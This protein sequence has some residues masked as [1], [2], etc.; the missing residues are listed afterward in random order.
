MIPAHFEFI[1]KLPTSESGKADIKYL[2]SLTITAF[3]RA[4][5]Y[6]APASE[7]ECELVAIWESILKIDKIGMRDNY[8]ELGGDSFKAIKIA[9]EY[10]DGVAV[11][12][13]YNS[14]TIAQLAIA[15]ES[16][17]ETNEGPLVRL[18]SATNKHLDN[19]SIIGFAHSAGHPINFRELENSLSTITNDIAIYAVNLR[20]DIVYDPEALY[21]TLETLTE[22]LA[23]NIEQT[24]KTPIVI[25]GQ[26]NGA[27][28]ALNVAQRL[29]QRGDSLKSVF[30][31]GSMLRM[32]DTPVDERDDE[33]IMD[34]LNFLGGTMPREPDELAFFLSDFRFDVGLAGCSFNKILRG[35]KENSLRKLSVP[36]YCIVGSDDPL[37]PGYEE[38]YKDWQ[39][40]SN[41]IYL[42]ILSDVGHYFLRDN[43]K[44][45]A[46]VFS[47]Y[48]LE[49]L[50]ADAAIEYG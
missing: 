29:D 19:L 16:A 46:S 37:T 2:K 49:T 44:D 9:S 47:Q 33:V 12:D 30:I 1:E 11:L 8:F 24:I 4:S 27:G 20:R 31:G 3:P 43:P 21:D 6:V 45:L 48:Y 14:P 40:I 5:S 10:G 28:L 36:L 35:I 7:I 50:Q 38:S 34:F 42:L 25:Y 23:D 32:G 17:A 18:S 26:C 41:S 39:Y 22:E 13:I 15:I